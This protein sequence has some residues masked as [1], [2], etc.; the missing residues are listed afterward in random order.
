[1]HTLPRPP[2]NRRYD[3]KNTQTV[4]IAPLLLCLDATEVA[5]PKENTICKGDFN[6]LTSRKGDFSNINA[7]IDATEVALPTA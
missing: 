5:L 4:L 3:T 6:R 1:M 2:P 7:S